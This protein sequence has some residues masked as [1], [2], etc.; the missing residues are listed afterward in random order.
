MKCPHCAQAFDDAIKECPGCGLVLAKWRPPGGSPGAGA[1]PAATAGGGSALFAQIKWL[2]LVSAA[3]AVGYRYLPSSRAQR[4][5]DQGRAYKQAGWIDQSRY[6]L[7]QAVELDPRGVGIKATRY[8]RTKLP[9]HPVPGEAVSRNVEA[10]N[11]MMSCDFDG[12]TAGFTALIRDYPDFEWPY[13]NLSVIYIKRNELAEAERT[14]RASLALNDCYVIGWL[15]LADA[16]ARAGDSA[17]RA[18][19]LDSALKCDPED[20]LA[21]A[22]KANPS[23]ADVSMPPDVAILCK[24]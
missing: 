6:A 1:A 17:G 8:M 16:K 19:A 14:L 7:S 22:M 23:V 10:Y 2:A 4:F 5:Y 15:H 20:N 13:G 21:L 12:A 18:A 11:R 3:L 9:S 24:N